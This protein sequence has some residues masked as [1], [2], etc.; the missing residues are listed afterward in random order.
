MT[1]DLYPPLA[2]RSPDEST[3]GMRSLWQVKGLM[4]ERAEML[5]K[6]PSSTDVTFPPK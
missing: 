1:A 6:Q 5:K 3:Q 4:K 2:G